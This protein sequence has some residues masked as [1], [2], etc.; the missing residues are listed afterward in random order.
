MK[1]RALKIDKGIPIPAQGG[2][3][4]TGHV[5]MAMKAMKKGDSLLI[6]GRVATNIY[7][8]ARKYIGKDKYTVR[9]V[10]GGFRVWRIA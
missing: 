5:Q 6:P 1:N 9:A 7:K 2:R 8:Q 3:K 10:E 4:G